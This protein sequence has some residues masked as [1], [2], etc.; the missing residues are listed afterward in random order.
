MR[1]S[2]PS[3]DEVIGEAVVDQEDQVRYVG[4]ILSRQQREPLLPV[5]HQLKL[6]LNDAGPRPTRLHSG[7]P[8][9]QDFRGK[10]IVHERKSWQRHV[11]T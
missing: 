10:L 1:I 7:F 11:I 2:P 9:V 5:L 6:H 8:A 3:L 4:A